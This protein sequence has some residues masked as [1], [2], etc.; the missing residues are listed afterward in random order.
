[1]PLCEMADVIAIV[2]DG[3]ATCKMADVNAVLEH[4]LGLTVSQYVDTKQVSSPT[5]Q[6]QQNQS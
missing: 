1:M 3:I 5:K 6:S 2:A 4:N